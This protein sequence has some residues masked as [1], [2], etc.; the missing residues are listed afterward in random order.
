MTYPTRSIWY[1]E[2]Y[3]PGIQKGFGYG[4]DEGTFDVRFFDIY[5][6]EKGQYLDFL[7]M[8]VRAMDE[9]L[10][11]VPFWSVSYDMKYLDEFV[12]DPGLI[13]QLDDETEAEGVVVR[14]YNE[15]PYLGSGRKVMKLIANSYL[16]KKQSEFK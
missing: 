4:L 11:I 9:E 1:G 13:S 5:D 10:K 2:I 16:L 7:D 12:N 14:S 6:W 3:G 8:G 15:E